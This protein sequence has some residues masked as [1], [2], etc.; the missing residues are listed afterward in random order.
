MEE[1]I[2]D[3]GEDAEDSNESN[4]ESDGFNS[5]EVPQKKL[6]VKKTQIKKEANN[7]EERVPEI[8]KKDKPYLNGTNGAKED[9]SLNGVTK[10]VKPNKSKLNLEKS[11]DSF[12]VTSSG[13]NYLANVK[14]VDSDESDT[15]KPEPARKPRFE[16]NEQKKPENGFT[17]KPFKPIVQ[18]KSEEK[19]FHPSW[20]AKQNQKKVVLGAQGSKIKFGDDDEPLAPPAPIVKYVKQGESAD[21]LHP[22]WLAKQK[23]K[24]TIKEFQGTKTTFDD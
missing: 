16:Q 18:P 7:S 9:Q 13:D 1:D 21:K 24:Q 2:S 4:I 22:S 19:E 10:R 8:I 6:K 14:N 15:E 3:A 12:F 5:V 23:Q 17:K 11:I 20:I